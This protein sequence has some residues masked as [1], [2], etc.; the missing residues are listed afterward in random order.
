MIE[1][2]NLTLA[3][4]DDSTDCESPLTH[5]G[6]SMP[7]QIDRSAALQI[8]CGMMAQPCPW[9]RVPNFA[10]MRTCMTEPS[11]SLHIAPGLKSAFTQDADLQNVE[12]TA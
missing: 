1:A 6:P 11:V 8:N 7:C 12:M 2:A 10:K 5:H 4:R 3:L 9:S